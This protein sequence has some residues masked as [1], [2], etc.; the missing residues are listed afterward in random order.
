MVSHHL[1]KFGDHRRCG[2]GDIMLLVAGEENSRCF[3]FSPL[4]L[5]ISKGHGLKVLDTSY[6]Q[7]QSWSHALQAATGQMFENNFYSSPSK[8]IDGKEK[9]KK[10]ETRLQRCLK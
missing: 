1:V 5:F 10:T 2:S 6:Y 9:K 7:L 3:H 8:S 4:I